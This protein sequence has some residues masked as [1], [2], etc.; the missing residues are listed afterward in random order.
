MEKKQ[1]IISIGREYGSGGHEIAERLAE[2]FGMPLY[3]HNMLNEIAREKGVDVE[4]IARYDER[5]RFSLSRTVRGH[6]SSPEANIAEMQFEY[7]RKKFREGESFVIVGRCS[8]T[9][10]KE[11]PGL[12]SVF[13][14][15]DE[16]FKIAR[17]MKKRKVDEEEARAMMHRH[18]KYRRAYHDTYCEAKW[19]NSN[20][21][22]LSVNSARLGIEGTIQLLAHYINQRADHI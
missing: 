15:A 21:Y 14:L 18:D 6:T 4:N 12:I 3:D 1:I 8:E 19:G 13:I 20:S 11:C 2:E 16:D 22:D 10:L 17:V 7:L 9:I 5:P